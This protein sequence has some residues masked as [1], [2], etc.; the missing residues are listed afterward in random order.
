M[1]RCTCKFLTGSAA[2]GHHSQDGRIRRFSYVSPALPGDTLA[3]PHDPA[4]PPSGVLRP[5]LTASA[6]ASTGPG[7]DPG[8]GAP[9][10]GG[11]G[12]PPGTET[13]VRRHGRNH[14]PPHR[15]HATA[16]STPTGSRQGGA[17]AAYPDS[18]FTIP[19]FHGY[20]TVLIWAALREAITGLA[21]VRTA[22]ARPDLLAGWPAR[23]R[24]TRS[25]VMT[26]SPSIGNADCAPV[27]DVMTPRAPA[28]RAGVGLRPI[29]LR[30][31]SGGGGCPGPFTG[32]GHPGWGGRPSRG[33]MTCTARSRPV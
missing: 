23:R 22:P 31:S 8:P 6:C 1:C 17:L 24:V 16:V 9:A 14:R 32:P 13:A 15:R 27:R 20:R 29:R 11:P 2:Q 28:M 5:D 33:R 26:V 18:F 19:H 10:A 12:A 25:G 30:G 4:H 21:G 3:T 7:P